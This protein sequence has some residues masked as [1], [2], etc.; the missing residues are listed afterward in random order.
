MSS[1]HALCI[2]QRAPPAPYSPCST[3]LSPAASAHPSAFPISASHAFNTLIAG[4]HTALMGQ[5]PSFVIA[6]TELLRCCCSS[7]HAD[8]VGGAF[9]RELLAMAALRA[10]TSCSKGTSPVAMLVTR[11]PGTPS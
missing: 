10:V 5:L 3:T 6:M 11:A 2:I 1:P 9:V 7:G 8:G 4:P